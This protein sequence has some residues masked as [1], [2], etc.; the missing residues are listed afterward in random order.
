MKF[1]KRQN[2][3]DSKKIS[4]YQGLGESEG[5]IEPRGFLGQENILYATTM[6]G[7]YYYVFVKT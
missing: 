6:V 7:I 2:Y 5:W 3:R 4:G 1:W